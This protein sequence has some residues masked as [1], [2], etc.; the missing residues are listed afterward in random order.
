MN[1]LQIAKTDLHT[2][3]GI[4]KVSSVQ[5]AERFDKEHK[6]I[7][8]D[9]DNLECSE[10]FNRLN[11]E[12][13][14]YKDSM[15]RDQKSYEITR[16]GC[17]FLI[18]GFTGAKAAAWK[19]AYV[20]AFNEMAE[21]LQSAQKTVYVLPEKEMLSDLFRL[22]SNQKALT[23][24]YFEWGEVSFGLAK[25]GGHGL[26]Y[27]VDK[28]FVD[29]Q[30]QGRVLNHY[31]NIH[32][33]ATLQ[34]LKREF[35]GFDVPRV[36]TEIGLSPSTLNRFADVPK[37]LLPS[38]Q[39]L[40]LG[41]DKPDIILDIEDVLKA[42]DPFC[43]TAVISFRKL[44]DCLEDYD[45]YGLAGALTSMGYVKIGRESINGHRHTLWSNKPNATG[46]EC[47]REITL[48]QYL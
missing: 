44:H 28:K 27:Y 10:E 30:L 25:I 12:P 13:I 33:G 8:R 37:F 45:A 42:D 5:I 14:S 11:F 38:E 18:M 35:K 21:E 19:E 40:A 34:E 47:K 31:L 15:N 36:L 1:E 24:D 32:P 22:A 48:R 46:K 41:S 6:N 39:K 3:E 9:I 20:N 16:D 4:I 17:A 43:N 29:T 23:M 7:L 26:N 2:V